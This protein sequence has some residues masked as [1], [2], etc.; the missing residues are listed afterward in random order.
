MR[1]K[2]G[3]LR[4]LLLVHSVR[5]I[6]SKIRFVY[7]AYFRRKLRTFD[8]ESKQI[9]AM[10]LQHNLKQVRGSPVPRSNK[11]L[12]PI[13]VIESVDP[14]LN[15]DVRVLSIG[16]RDEGELLGLVGLGYSAKNIIGLDLISYSP[17]VVLGDM[18][19]MQLDSNSFDAVVCGWVLSYSSDRQ[20]AAN[21]IIRVTKDGGVIAV[22]VV[23]NPD[24][25]E[26]LIEKVGYLPGDEERIQDSD[27]ILGLFGSSVDYVYF[28][29]DP[30]PSRSDVPGTISVI[31]SIQK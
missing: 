24:S 15:P 5:G 9:S 1:K 22:G 18:H 7:F 27:E 11:L 25:K 29:H 19:D 12:R 31:F 8:V 21:E 6:I 23:R 4:E 28:R 3:F 2:R 10:A 26:N 14:L 30:P 16:P 17:W 20:T 13:S